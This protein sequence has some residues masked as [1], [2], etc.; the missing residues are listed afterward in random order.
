MIMARCKHYTVPGQPITWKRPGLHRGEFFD[1]QTKSKMA[2][3]LHL[4]K[5]HGDE[6]LFQGPVHLDV[7]YYFKRS[8]SAGLLTSHSRAPDID[9]LCKF[10]FDV[11][12]DLV[13]T[14]DKIIAKLTAHKV[15]DD[16]PRTEFTIT[17]I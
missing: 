4:D 3:G 6:A 15:Y 2:I 5:Q 11:L 8:K 17:E 13:I 14:D 12:T 1:A 9:N 7:V 16:N 10:L